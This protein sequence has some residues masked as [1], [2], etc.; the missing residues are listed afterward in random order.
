MRPF[1]VGPAFCAGT[2]KTGARSS[3]GEVMGW[4]GREGPLEVVPVVE[5]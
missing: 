4:R 5:C 1:L 3:A 2:G